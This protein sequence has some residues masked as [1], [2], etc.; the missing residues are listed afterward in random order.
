MKDECKHDKHYASTASGG[1]V[2]GIGMLGAFVFFI[3]HA[4]SFMAGLFGVFQAIFWP[5][6]LVYYAFQALIK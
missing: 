3:T 1:A 6:F 5:A 4:T 2:Y